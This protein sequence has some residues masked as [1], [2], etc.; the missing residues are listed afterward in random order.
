[1]IRR[2]RGSLALKVVFTSCQED[3]S[4][5]IY[6]K[7][8]RIKLLVVYEESCENHVLLKK[9]INYMTKLTIYILVEVIS[10]F[11]LKLA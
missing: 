2:L 11:I 6:L 5:S 3:A 1:M 8:I 10:L 7:A 4:Y 9:I